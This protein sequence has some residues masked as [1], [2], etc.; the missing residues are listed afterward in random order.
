MLAISV[1]LGRTCNF[2]PE[3]YILSLTEFGG[4]MGNAHRHQTC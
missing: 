2:N 1:L 4:R 3:Q